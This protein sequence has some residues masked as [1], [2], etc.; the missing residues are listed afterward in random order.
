MKIAKLLAA[1]LMAFACTEAAADWN[2]CAK[3][4]G[5]CAF[6]GR[7]EVAY[8]AGNSWITKVFTNGVKCGSAQFGR[9]PAPGV[10]KACRVKDVAL[11]QAGAGGWTPCAREDGFCRFEG[12]KEVAY[13]A[14]D[15]WVRKVFADGVKCSHRVFG[16][17]AVGVHKSC[18]FRDVGAPAASSGT[19]TA[20]WVRCAQEGGACRF[21]G[22][23]NVAYGAEGKYRY[24]VAKNAVACGNEYFGDPAPGKPK[25]CFIDPS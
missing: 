1:A 22:T 5:F 23:R 19:V 10:A 3:E 14:G 7:R 25:A 6:Q 17:P 13:G 16:D 18:Q 21:Q 24:R 15:K 11:S 8:G 9:D 12:R 4:D 20:K 2:P